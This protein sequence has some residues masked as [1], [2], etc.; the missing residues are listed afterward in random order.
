MAASG[1]RLVAAAAGQFGAQFC[2][3]S[4]PLNMIC[5]SCWPERNCTP[6]VEALRVIFA[7]QEQTG[8]PERALEVASGTGQHVY[9]LARAFP[10]MIWQPTELAEENLLSIQAYMDSTTPNILPPTSL[11]A[12]QPC[13]TWQ[14]PGPWDLILSINMVC[15]WV[16]CNW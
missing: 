3:Y 1:A 8:F 2:C 5:M 10:Q 13:G 12:S 9:A 14:V 6:I 11:D 7:G 16:L 4:T 15:H